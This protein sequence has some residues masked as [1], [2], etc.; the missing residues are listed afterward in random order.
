MRLTSIIIY[1][2]CILNY[3]YSVENLSLEETTNAVKLLLL[4]GLNCVV[5]NQWYSSIEDGSTDLEDII[6]GI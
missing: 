5:I 4:V 1:Y 6:K 3:L 2:Y